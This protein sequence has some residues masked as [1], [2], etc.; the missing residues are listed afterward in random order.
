MI[1]PSHEELK[2]RQEKD[3]NFSIMWSTLADQV[4]K[5]KPKPC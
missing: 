4:Q 1:M 5:K 2:K 3:R